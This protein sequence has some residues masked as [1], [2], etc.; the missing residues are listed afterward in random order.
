MIYQ[1]AKGS[2]GELS[3][4]FRKAEFACKCSHCSMVTVD[5]ELVDILQRIRDH[6]GKPVNIN[7]GYRCEKHNAEV[8][9]ATGS[10]HTKGMAADIRVKGV[11]PREVAKFAESIGVKRIGLYEGDEGEFVHIGSDKSKRFWLGHGIKIVDTFGGGKEQTD[12]PA[13]KFK[14]GDIVRF[15]GGNHYASSNASS[16]PVVKE[17]RAKITDVYE[18]GIH[19]YH[20][21]AVNDAG[22]YI[23]GVYGWVNETDLSAP[24]STWTPKIGDVVVYNGATH[25]S[26]ANAV[27]GSACKGGQAKITNIYQ[28][29]KSKHPYHLVRVNGKGASVYGWVDEGTFTKV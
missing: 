18:A 19:P 8:G 14:K 11:A 1:Y 15:G 12:K 20:C 22:A 3:P 9:G 6:F 26:N 29:G 23:D 28:L 13:L 7:S 4:N 10:H 5:M 25:Y 21:R 27:S 16:G 24:E 17:S 2:S